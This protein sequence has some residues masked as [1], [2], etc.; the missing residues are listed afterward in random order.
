MKR[1]LDVLEGPKNC[2][3]PAFRIST[4]SWSSL[5]RT[6]EYSQIIGNS[7]APYINSLAT[8]GALFTNSFA[9]TH[10]S[11]P[12]YLALFSGS[13]QGVTDDNSHTFSGAESRHTAQ[14]RGQNVFSATPKRQ[15]SASTIRGR[16]SPTPAPTAV[17]SRASPATS[18]RCR[19]FRL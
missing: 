3:Q 14:G 16:A 5:K 19:T 15:L 11:Q 8:S 4:R 6:T 18:A 13:T 2:F 7:N 1:F 10:P 9:V 17:T 12:N